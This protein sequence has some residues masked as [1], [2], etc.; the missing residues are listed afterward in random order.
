MAFL[1]TIL[2]LLLLFFCMRILWR[3]SKPYIMRYI[4]KK[5]GQKFEQMADRYSGRA[6]PPKPDGSTTIINN[7]QKTQSTNKTVGEYVDYEEID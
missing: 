3:L 4:A 5:A 7:T 6:T 1:R 2:I